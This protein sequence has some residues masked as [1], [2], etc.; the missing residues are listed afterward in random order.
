VAKVLPPPDLGPLWHTEDLAVIGRVIRSSK[1][2]VG[3]KHYYHWHKVFHMSPPDGLTTEQWWFGLKL[4]RGTSARPLP[5]SGKSG[6]TFTFNL[7][8]SVIEMLHKIDQLASG[9]IQ[10][11]DTVT[12]PG[13]RDRYVMNSLI[14]EAITS[15]Q[16]EG[17]STTRK[18]AKEM[19]RSGRPPRDRDERMILNNYLAMQRV[20]E[21][22]DEPLTPEMICE[23]HRIVTAGT[24]EDPGAAGRPQTP[25]EER[26]A[27]CDHRTNE[28]LH[29]PPPAA[30]TAWRL[31]EVCD[32]A[33][34]LA[35]TEAFVHPVVRA[36]AVH[37]A[38]GFIHPF[39][40]GNGRTARALFYWSM[41][42]Q[43]Y[44]L[45][46]FLT[47]SAILKKA[48]GKY[49]EAFQ[50]VE[51]DEDDLTYFLVYQLEVILRAIDELH[52]Y[53]DRKIAEV[54]EAETLARSY[55]LNHRQLALLGNAMRNVAAAYTI[56]SHATSHNCV[57][58]TARTDLFGLVERGLL[59]VNRVGRADVFSPPPDL[60]ARLK[61]ASLAV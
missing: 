16:L 2:L 55:G 21:L 8:D 38:F 34:N 27:V 42:S 10:I 23:L 9:S 32:F 14:E 5:L 39:E 41:L 45:T 7:I 40:D 26:I 1:G 13:T 59:V 25:D 29:R 19:L 31:R 50:Y 57:R 24:L 37:F 18:V 61:R 17:A 49:T 6:G 15:S 20:R 43:G 60:V 46:E 44:W 4:A 3:G 30:E 33:N 11:S 12:N 28:I 35:G 58:Q 56:R 53:L 48:P 52:E 51:T 22:V 47:I 54:R 36:I